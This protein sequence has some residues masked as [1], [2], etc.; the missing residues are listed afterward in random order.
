MSREDAPAIERYRHRIPE[1]TDEE[2]DRLLRDGASPSSAAA[3]IHYTFGTLRGIPTTQEFVADEFGI[4][5]SSVRRWYQHL[6]E[7]HWEGS[8]PRGTDVNESDIIANP[9]VDPYTREEYVE[10]LV[11]RYDLRKQDGYRDSGYEVSKH[12]KITAIGWGKITGAETLPL[13]AEILESEFELIPG[14]DFTVFVNLHEPHGDLDDNAGLLRVNKSGVKKVYQQR[15]VT[16]DD[17]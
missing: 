11:E 4:S 15:G 1:G 17:D 2:F 14:E 3:A 5:K 6:V 13:V 7:L 12:G 10:Q 16:A 8:I 9:E